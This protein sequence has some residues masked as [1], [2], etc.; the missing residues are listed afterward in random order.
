LSFEV[1]TEVRFIPND[2]GGIRPQV[3]ART[4]KKRKRGKGVVETEQIIP[5]DDTGEP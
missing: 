2:A 4:V 1:K 3:R 5:P